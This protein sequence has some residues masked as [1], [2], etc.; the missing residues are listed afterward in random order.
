MTDFI[1]LLKQIRI[2]P[3]LTVHSEEEALATCQALQA[4]GIKA[5]EITLRTDAGLSSLAAVKEAMPDFKVGA[6]TVK[7]AIDLEAVAQLDVDFAVS[8]GLSKEVVMRAGDLS[9]PMLPGIATPTEL[10]AGLELGC[11][12]FKLFPAE[13]VGGIPMLESLSAPFAEAVF[14]PTGGIGPNNYR[15]YLA[16]PNVVCL[17]GSW[18]VSRELIEAENPGWRDLYADLNR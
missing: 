6:G 9:I 10:M 18:M 12:C 8:P 1:E 14:C 15:D 16:L 2:I 4:G 3:V 11:R 13:A 7:T 5:V 17:G